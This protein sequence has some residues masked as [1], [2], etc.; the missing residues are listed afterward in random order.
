MTAKRRY[1]RAKAARD[2]VREMLIDCERLLAVSYYEWANAGD[3]P[4]AKALFEGTVARLTEDRDRLRERLDRAEEDLTR[5]VWRHRF[6]S[7]FGTD[8][9]EEEA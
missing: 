6:G 9:T 3:H 2:R 5:A 4:D 8:P 7:E 1:E